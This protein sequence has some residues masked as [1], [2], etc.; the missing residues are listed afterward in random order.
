MKETEETIRER[1]R[2]VIASIDGGAQY[3]SAADAFDAEIERVAGRVELYLV[4]YRDWLDVESLLE[5]LTPF[6]R[7]SFKE[8]QS[9]RRRWMISSRT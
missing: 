8:I 5:S 7:P 4:A 6:H 9:F 3:L 2:S 1:Y